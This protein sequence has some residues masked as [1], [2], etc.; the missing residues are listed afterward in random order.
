MGSVPRLLRLYA[1]LIG[2]EL[3][4]QLA[5]RASFLV[6]AAGTALVTALEFAALALVF[7]RFDGLGG[8][9]LTE[10]AVLYGLVALSFGLADLLFAGF[11]PR[12]FGQE[13]R[14]G[15]LDQKLLRPVPV[16]LQVLGADFALRRLGKVA[17]GAAVLAYGLA[18]AAP[19]WS[20]AKATYLPLVALGMVLFFGGLFVAGA[21]VTFWTIESIEAVNVLTY[22][23]ETLISYPMHIYDAW[24]RRLFT[25]VVPAL[26]LAYAPALYLLGRPDPLGLPP[27]T[28][29]VA[30][31]AGGLAFAA[32]LAFWRVGLRRYA[33]TGT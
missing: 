7:G 19:A 8:W 24:L 18:G 25:W 28:R 16:G 10:V 22:G 3:R 26:F 32:A 27:W 11:D 13:V 17:V 4:S 31:L 2:A 9:P 15:L 30:P 14:R 33:S 5:Y 1:R 29:F 20:L 12:R 21:T 6:D 23:T